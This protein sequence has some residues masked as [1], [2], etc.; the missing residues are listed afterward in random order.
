MRKT[1]NYSLLTRSRLRQLANFFSSVCNSWF[2]YLEYRYASCIS[3]N[4]SA[5]VLYKHR[6]CN[7][8]HYAISLSGNGVCRINSMSMS[9]A[10]SSLL[11]KIGERLQ[12]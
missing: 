2:R 7:T 1:T 9:I 12:I 4:Y 8:S 6:T 3:S 11:T 10:V 5:L